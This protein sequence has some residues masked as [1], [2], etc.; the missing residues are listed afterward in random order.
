MHKLTDRKVGLWVRASGT[1]AYGEMVDLLWQ[2]GELAVA[3]E[4]ER[5]WNEAIAELDIS[6]LCAYSSEAGS[7]PEHEVTLHEVCRLHTRVSGVPG[8]PVRE[9]EPDRSRETSRQF[10]PDSSAPRAARRFLEQTLREW[11]Y[12]RQT[13]DD[14]RLLVS[15]LVTNAV[16]H[17]G[18]QLE[19]VIHGERPGLRVEVHD[20]SRIDPGPRPYTSEPVAGGRGLRL[21]DALGADWGVERT[22][23]GKIVWADLGGSPLAGSIPLAGSSPSSS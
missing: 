19:V 18:S 12:E 2:R 16:V 7:A 22:Q 14:A 23:T 3:I 6:L 10:E 21:I 8:T 11:G 17:A 1:W 9:I 5:R 20:R 15:E 13:V 4:L